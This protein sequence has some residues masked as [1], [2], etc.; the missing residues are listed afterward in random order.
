MTMSI[1]QHFRKEEQPF[2]D[3][4]LSWKEQ[5]EKSYQAKLTDFLDPR[6]QQIIETVIGTANDELQIKKYGGGAFT[7]RKRV[8]IAPF[9]EEV[10]ANS[11]QL[12]LMQAAYPEKFISITHPDVMGGFL[13][14]GIDRKKLGDIFVEDGKIQ[15]V[16]ASEIAPYILANL[17][18][19]KRA[20]VTMTEVPLSKLME[21][22]LH[23]EEAEK[24][25]SSLRLDTIVKEIYR[26]S[27]KDAA[28]YITKR[29]VKVNFKVVNDVKFQ[30]QEGDL[31]SL[32]GQGRSRLVSVNG[33]TKKGK[34][35]I[36]IA[37]LK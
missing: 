35:K 20:N 4:V 25:V 18:S 30:L 33:N 28:A 22:E 21:K 32:R 34:L 9:Y 1:Y 13:S 19:I 23:W 17:T 15:I 16:T 31:I 6:E 29:L 7:E 26:F 36:T 27:R 2:V 11:F 24:T 37:T 5:V 14:L 3:Q 8:V 10:D 12:I